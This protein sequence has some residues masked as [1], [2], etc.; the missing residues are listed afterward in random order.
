MIIWQ[1]L[2]GWEARTLGIQVTL[3]PKQQTNKGKWYRH[4]GDS[5]NSRRDPSVEMRVEGQ[6]QVVRR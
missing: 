3:L 4:T 1:S 6:L 5:C 2:W